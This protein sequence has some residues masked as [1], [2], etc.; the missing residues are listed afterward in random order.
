MS[1]TARCGRRRLA[2]AV[3]PPA[4]ALVSCLERRHDRIGT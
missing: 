1:T 4:T 3:A 2:E